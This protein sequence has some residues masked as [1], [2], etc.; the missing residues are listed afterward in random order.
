MAKSRTLGAGDNVSPSSSFTI[1]ESEG[2]FAPTRQ[3]V[4]SE[5][6]ALNVVE[7]YEGKRKSQEDFDVGSVGRNNWISHGVFLRVKVAL[8]QVFLPYGYPQ[9]V[10]KDYVE[11]QCWDTVQVKFKLNYLKITSM[12]C[13]KYKQTK[14]YFLQA[15]ASSITGA[16]ATEAVM[17]GVGVGESAATPLAAA[18]T[19]LLKS[20]SGHI[21]QIVFAWAKGTSLDGNCKQWRLFADI[22][23]DCATLVDL[24]APLA[25]QK[26]VVF[27][28][29]GASVA[30]ALVGVAGG[31][32]RAAV[33]VHQSRANNMGDVSAKD[34]SQETLVNL[35]ALI[36]SLILL[37]LV[38]GN[39]T[40][41]FNIELIMRDPLC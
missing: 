16:L 17:K 15:F 7:F 38:S 21:G 12:T 4:F 5:S 26:A 8:R 2:A 14:Y 31:A 30:R 22:L 20:G 32:T 1:S 11:Y 36:T 27:V 39:P 10:S 19:W 28:L 37:P 13:I 24:L 23:N 3:Y 35:V 9:S 6:G 29:C 34:G 41:V 40:L 18:L 25:P 33:T